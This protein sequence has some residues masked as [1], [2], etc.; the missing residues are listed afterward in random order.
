MKKER[1]EAATRRLPALQLVSMKPDA[2][3]RSL[4]T[5]AESDDMV[6]GSS[7]FA[8]KHKV[9]KEALL[10]A[11]VG[12]ASG[13]FIIDSLWHGGLFG[14]DLGQNWR[15]TQEALSIGTSEDALLSFLKV[16]RSY[17]WLNITLDDMRD[18]ISFTRFRGGVDKL[19]CDWCALIN[20]MTELILKKLGRFP[21]TAEFPQ[22]SQE[23]MDSAAN[24]AV[25]LT[26]KQYQDVHIEPGDDE[27]SR[28]PNVPKSI[29]RPILKLKTMAMTLESRWCPFQ[30]LQQLN[31]TRDYYCYNPEIEDELMQAQKILIDKKRL[32]GDDVS[33]DQCNN[34]LVKYVLDEPSVFDLAPAGMSYMDR[35]RHA[36]G[37][38]AIVF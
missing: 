6:V 38:E 28:Y 15:L 12:L 37:I 13:S 2:R 32:T 21:S 36:L 33:L 30:H 9:A 24:E 18:Y 8:Q 14:Q 17:R 27:F 4:A 1:L 34:Q 23:S 5:E 10:A 20:G 22:L 7:A 29:I 11:E 3:S 25:A 26:A 19:N 31:F 35:V 16:C